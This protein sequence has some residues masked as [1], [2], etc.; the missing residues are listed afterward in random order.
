MVNGKKVVIVTQARIGSTRFPK[1]V[2]QKLGNKTLIDHHIDRLLKVANISKVIVA[3]TK[4]EGIDELLVLL[5]EKEVEVFQGSTD[6][7]LDR[8]FN[9]VKDENPDYVVR[10]TSDC[11]LI[12][13]KLIDEVIA[14]T[15]ENELDYGS[16][17]LIELF[18]DGQDIEVFR[19]S[20][21]YKA[22]NEAILSSDKEHVTPYIRRN[23]TF[24][25][26]NLFRSDNYFCERDYNS[27]RMTVDEKPDLEACEIMLSKLGDAADWITYADFIIGNQELFFNQKIKRN[28]G[29]EK[30]LNSD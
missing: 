27:V 3:T 20:A 19:L 2:I 22:F 17:I 30:S 21:L 26:G 29:F 1:K 6:N 9:A 13:P 15:I 8:F 23:S 16:N 25:G 12:D 5:Y 7:V 14:F 11:P 18:P 24:S 4:E 28:E 10:V